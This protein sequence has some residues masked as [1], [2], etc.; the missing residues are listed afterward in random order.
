MRHC[1]PAS[2]AV[3]RVK[4]DGSPA[5]SH[6]IATALSHGSQW[7]DREGREPGIAATA[8]LAFGAN[9]IAA[10]TL[11]QVTAGVVTWDLLLLPF[12][13]LRDA[14]G[15]PIASLLPVILYMLL[16]W[17]AMEWLRRKRWII[18]I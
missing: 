6:G 5:P 18:K 8:M 2:R 11:H 15:D 7:L 13:A 10:Y 3:E 14:L 1:H 16:I 4:G 9:A 12:R 17:G